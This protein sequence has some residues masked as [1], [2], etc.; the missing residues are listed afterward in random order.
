MELAITETLGQFAPTPAVI[1]GS[2]PRSAPKGAV[3][4]IF[5]EWRNL[6]PKEP[7]T[8]TATPLRSQCIAKVL[9][10]FAWIFLA[11]H[12]LRSATS[13]S[14]YRSPS[15]SPILP[16]LIPQGPPRY[17]S[18]KPRPGNRSPDSPVGECELQQPAALDPWRCALDA[19]KDRPRVQLFN[20]ASYK[21]DGQPL[22]LCQN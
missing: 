4:S 12:Q 17:A 20:Q 2:Q 7:F 22:S 8:H 18:S 1:S 15:I 10:Y 5:C 13:S 19:H 14:F 11:S 21:H 9:C 3:I 6:P 16:E